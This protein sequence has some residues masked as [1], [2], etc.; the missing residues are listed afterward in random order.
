V[1]SGLPKRPDCSV[2]IVQ[3]VD[4]QF[5]A[6]LAGWLSGYTEMRVVTA[7]EGMA[8]EPGAVILAATNDHLVLG[9]DLALRYT[10]EPRDQPYRPSVDVFFASLR[11]YWPEP[12]IAA[13]LTGMGR[14][15]ANGLLALRTAGWHTIAQDERT[16]V[17]YGMPRA[18]AEIGAAAE[19]LPI[20]AIGPA[21]AKHL[22][23]SVRDVRPGAISI[24]KEV[25]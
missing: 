1:L 6:G 19:I 4:Q 16:S 24:E 11:R 9:A 7:R 12:G 18:A 2:V 17:V 13:L 14:D 8:V 23:R 5:A 15:G 21:I 20:E 22:N 10:L 3:H 25:S